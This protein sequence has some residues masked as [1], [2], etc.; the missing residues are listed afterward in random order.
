MQK[1][2]LFIFIK[3]EQLYVLTQALYIVG[4]IGIQLYIHPGLT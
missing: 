1:H 2:T 3:V 4:S